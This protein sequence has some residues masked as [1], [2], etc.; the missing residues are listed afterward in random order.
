MALALSS[1]LP[2]KS[3]QLNPDALLNAHLKQHVGKAA[4][5]GDKLALM[6][7]AIGALRRIQV[8]LERVEN[9]AGQKGA[10]YA[11]ESIRFLPDQQVNVLRELPHCSYSPEIGS[12]RI[13]SAGRFRR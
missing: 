7:I 9:Y 4:P 12:K 5:A 2:G 3:P 1:Y 10:A 13:A 11:D 6:R 8:Q